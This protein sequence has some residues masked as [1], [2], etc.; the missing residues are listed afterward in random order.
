MNATAPDPTDAHLD[1][2]TIRKLTWQNNLVTDIA[3]RIVQAALAASSG[4][5]PDELE[6][7]DV[8]A[9]SK[10]TI[11]I[12]WRLLKT[13]K[14]IEPTADFRRS[15]PRTAARGRIIF[16]YTIAS[17]SR[18]ATFLKRN[19]ASYNPQPELCL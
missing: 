15:K 14:I 19:G 6:W 4:L 2:V 12:A 11:G 1:A 5:W 16:R 3:K 13:A 10:N 8:P 18:A 17:H 7:K 9:E